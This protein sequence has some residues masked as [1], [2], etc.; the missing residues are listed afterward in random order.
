MKL[1]FSA[2]WAAIAL[3]VAAGA[4]QAA[5]VDDAKMAYERDKADCMTGRTAEPR[6]LCLKEAAAAYADARRGRL[7]SDGSDK[8]QYAANAAKRCEV[9]KGEQRDL[10]LRRVAGE[11][12]VSG[13]VAQGGTLDELVTTTPTAAGPQTPPPPPPPPQK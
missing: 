13:S 5:P 3:A 1:H 2:R 9:Q 4:A 10:C 8:S 6:A 12:T 11:G 7:A